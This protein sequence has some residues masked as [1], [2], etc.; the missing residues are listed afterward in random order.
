MKLEIKNLNKSYDF[1][2]FEN[3]NISFDSN[4]I[5]LTGENG[6]GKSTLLKILSGKI[7]YE[8][9]DIFLNGYKVDTNYLAENTV[10]ID[11][12]INLFKR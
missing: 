1:K 8:S 3:L 7:K 11:Q 12:K 6:S 9:G 5:H 4:L 10:L 2:V